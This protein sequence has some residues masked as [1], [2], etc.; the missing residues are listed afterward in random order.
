ME[1]KKIGI[2]G[3]GMVGGAL[4]Q[5]FE[6]QEV[7]MLWLDPGKEFK[8]DVNQAD[9]IF[10]CVPTPYKDELKA[11]DYSAID[12]SLKKINAG[13]IVIIKSTVEI[14]ITQM[15]AEKYPELIL[16]F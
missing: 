12:E 8:D 1:K 14:G 3:L 4:A 13:K 16:L 5:W 10:I 15:F 2:A 11:Y 9:Y 7:K 6:K